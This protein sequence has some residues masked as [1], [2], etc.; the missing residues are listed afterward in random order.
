MVV[1]FYAENIPN[2]NKTSLRV[3]LSD[4]SKGINT[5]VTENILPL[6]YAVNAYNFDF[7]SGALTEGLGLKELQIKNSSTTKTMITPENVTKIKKFWH[8][9]RYDNA[10]QQFSPLLM[11]YCDDGKVYTGRLL[12]LDTNFY[13]VGISFDTEPIGINYRLNEDDSFLCCAPN[14]IITYNGN[15]SPVTYTENVPNITSVA[16]HAGRLFA[17]TGGDQSQLWF[18][19][20]LDPTNWNVSE[21]EG[22]YIELTD[23]RGTLKKVIE[24]NNY[25]YVIREY[26]ISRVSGWGLQDE[27]TVRN[28]YLTTGK[29]YYNTAVLC[30]GGII[31]LCRDG[32]Y[33]FTGSSMQKLD[34]GLDKYFENVDN[35]YAIGAFLDGK[36][37][38]ACKLNFDDGVSVGCENSTYQNN[39]LI[40]YDL[41]NGNVNILRGVDICSLTPFQT[42]WFS[43]LVVCRNDDKQDKLAELTHDGQIFGVS[44]QKSWTS[45][46]TDMGYPSYKK[47]IK[48]LFFTTKYDVQV[49]FNADG[50]DY[51]FEAKGADT[52]TKLP[53]NIFAKRFNITFTTNNQNCEISNPELEVVLC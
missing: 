15:V 21:F 12:T 50:K 14:K 11:I 34:L 28:L 29:L 6:N 9:R 33:Y 24:S 52:P 49:I 25:L 7:N 26:G 37:Y 32:L 45:A 3:K 53:I 13:D 36:Y 17:T 40:E 20:D 2:L 38:L 41:D 47:A 5:T 18:S 23:E 51:T 39:A 48:N 42:E 10:M 22:G 46:Y 19:D 8:F 31:M 4:F 44:T 35:D 27:F 16:L 1:V 30:G 43:K